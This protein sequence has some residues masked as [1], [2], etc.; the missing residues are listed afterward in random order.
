[1]AAGRADRLAGGENPRPGTI[2]ALMALRSAADS[3]APSPRL[4][5]VVNPA[6]KVRRAYTVD[7]MA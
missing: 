3:L 4:R 6:S 5:T 1:M 2:P 7:R